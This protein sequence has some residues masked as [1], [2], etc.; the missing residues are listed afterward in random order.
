MNMMQF[1]PPNPDPNS[2]VP[3]ESELAARY[4]WPPLFGIILGIVFVVV[5]VLIWCKVLG[6]GWWVD[7]RVR[8]TL[9]VTIILYGIYRISVFYPRVI[10]G[11]RKSL[12]DQLDDLENK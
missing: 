10:A 4:G 9:S 12:Q 7:Y 3:N 5:G 11:N 1:L 8:I 6:S 2:D